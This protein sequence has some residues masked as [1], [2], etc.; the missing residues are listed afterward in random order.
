MTQELYLLFKIVKNKKVALHLTATVK[1]CFKNNSW[2]SSPPK[3]SQY[4]VYVSSFTRCQE[5]TLRYPFIVHL[6]KLR[7]RDAK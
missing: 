5:S 1:C 2:N 3:S 6:G 7:H 4:S